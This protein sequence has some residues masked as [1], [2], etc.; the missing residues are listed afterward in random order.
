M[1]REV[2]KHG[3]EDHFEIPI[4]LAKQTIP[5]VAPKLGHARMECMNAGKEHIFGHHYSRPLH[6]VPLQSV[7]MSVL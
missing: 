7:P 6:H 5:V 2:R 3:R 1:G 4:Q